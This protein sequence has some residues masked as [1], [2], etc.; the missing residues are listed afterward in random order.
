MHLI[1]AFG[2]C[3][4]LP[5]FL[6]LH[7]SQMMVVLSICRVVLYTK[8]FSMKKF[9][10][11]PFIPFAGMKNSFRH[12][13]Q[14]ILSPGFFC[15]ASP[16]RLRHSTQNVWMHGNILGSV[17]TLM[18]IGHSVISERCSAAF[19]SSFAILT[20]HVNI[21]NKVRSTT[22]PTRI[23]RLFF[24]SQCRIH[25]TLIDEVKLLTTPLIKSDISLA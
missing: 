13:G 4:V 16:V 25:P 7:T 11:T 3:P 9:F 22:I 12:S 23:N 2:I 17:N 19:S 21:L 1:V 15:S 8:R 20:Y 24:L 14:G 5:L 10:C 18:Q 6:I